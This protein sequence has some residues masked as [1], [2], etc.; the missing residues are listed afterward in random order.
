MTFEEILPELR[1]G[2][3]VRRQSYYEGLIIFMQNPAYIQI[4]LVSNMQS[5]PDDA[6]KLLNKFDCPVWYRDQFI[7]YDFGTN[8]ATYC[9][10]DGEDINA[11]D[12]EVVD[13]DNYNPYE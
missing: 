13:I 9:I 7:I 1:E 6:K 5:L 2:K 3:V 11:T 12:W 10:L 8:V 4:D